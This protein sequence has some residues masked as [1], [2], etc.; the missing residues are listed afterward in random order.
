MRYDP[1]QFN[2]IQFNPIQPNLY[3]RN[4]L[5]PTHHFHYKVAIF[6]RNKECKMIT[7]YIV[8][9][10]FPHPK[11]VIGTPHR[12]ESD[13]HAVTMQWDILYCRRNREK[14]W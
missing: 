5:P 12:V 6:N 2:S 3:I 7:S 4:H 11:I 1:I 8:H 13:V 10:N 14:V 9:S